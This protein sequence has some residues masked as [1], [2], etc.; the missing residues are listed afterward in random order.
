[1]AEP[2]LQSTLTCPLCGRQATEQMPTDACLYFYDC[3]GCGETLKPRHGD[4]CVFCSYGS[5]P[6]PPVQI[7]RA[8]GGSAC[9]GSVSSDWVTSTQSSLV[10]WWLPQVAMIVTVFAKVPFRTVVWA[11]ALAWM[12]VACL[13]NARQCSRTHCR[14]TGPYYLAAVAPVLCRRRRG[15]FSQPLRLAGAWCFNSWWRLCHLVGHRA[16]L[17][18]VFRALLTLI[19]H[20]TDVRLAR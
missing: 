4:C 2:Q 7:A 16:R 8:A 15:C 19:A 11:A 1:M 12:G 13:L 10:A 20:E 17:G 18:Q 6:C 9:C 5:V 14:Y 3:R